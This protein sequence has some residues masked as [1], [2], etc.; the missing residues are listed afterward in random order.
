MCRNFKIIYNME[1]L[2]KTVKILKEGGVVIFPTDTVY[3]FVADATNKKGVAKI[4]NIKKRPKSKP[5]PV[6]VSGIKMAR[7]VAEIDARQVKIL[8]KFWPGKYTFI[9]KRK[10]G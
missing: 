10:L 5:L 6:F 7:E 8:K 3:G 9:L 2:N 4:Y 1:N